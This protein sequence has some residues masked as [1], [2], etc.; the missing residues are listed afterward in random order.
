MIADDLDT[1]EVWQASALEL[2]AAATI[3]TP[4]ATAPATKALTEADKP[5]PSDM[6]ATASR[7]A[8]FPATQSSPA[9]TPL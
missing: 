7:I 6:F 5:S 8:L 3:V 1:G 9:I 2:P 4:L